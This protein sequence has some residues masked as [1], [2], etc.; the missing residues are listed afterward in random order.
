M[1]ESKKRAPVP[2]RVR[3]E[4]Q[5]IRAAKVDPA[6][7]KA[8]PFNGGPYTKEWLNAIS[9]KMR[10]TVSHA[11]TE[12]VKRVHADTALQKRIQDFKKKYP[13]E[14]PMKQ[15]NLLV[16][17]ATHRQL[18]DL[19][20]GTGMHGKSEYL[21]LLVAYFAHRDFRDVCRTRR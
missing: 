14:P 19:H 7:K 17:V 21:R 10:K 20:Y 2:K 12:L 15:V 5:F 9:I 8:L 11:L 3:P 13:A 1:P 4:Q 18:E 6:M 16:S